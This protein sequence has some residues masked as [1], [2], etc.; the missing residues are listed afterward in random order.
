MCMYVILRYSG[1]P[2]A[3]ALAQ[4]G[5]CSERIQAGKPWR[6]VVGGSREGRGGVGPAGLRRQ[7]VS[8]LQQL[9]PLHAAAEQQLWFRNPISVT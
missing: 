6:G 9:P 2:G 7:A 3:S 4:A 1:D 8:T 5:C